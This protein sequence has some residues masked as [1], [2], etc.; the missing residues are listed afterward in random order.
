MLPVKVFGSV[1]KFLGSVE[2]L[3]VCYNSYAA[4]TELYVVCDC[5][6]VGQSVRGRKRDDVFYAG[7]CGGGEQVI[8][9]GKR[10]GVQL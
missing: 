10:E 1:Q 4:Y 9:R 2:S 8:M 5:L 3:L 7:V 6:F